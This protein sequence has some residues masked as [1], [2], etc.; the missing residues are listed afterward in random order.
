MERFIKDQV[1]DGR[2]TNLDEGIDAARLKLMEEP[3][4]A[5]RTIVL[6]SD[7]L[8]D[9]DPHHGK[10][11]LEELSSRVPKGKFSFYLIDLSGG[12]YPG[13]SEMRL[14]SFLFHTWLRESQEAP[15]SLR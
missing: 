12:S 15:D 9:P 13:F 14:G 8:S 10:V 2:Y 3:G 5:I 6:I 7:G 11:K 4:E 1:A